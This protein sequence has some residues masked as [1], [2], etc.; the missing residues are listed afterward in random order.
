M[1]FDLLLTDMQMPEMDGYDAARWLRARGSE[2]PILALTAHAM[3]EELELC[4]AAGCN[5]YATKPIIKLF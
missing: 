4:V 1:P 5:A 3:T 2:L